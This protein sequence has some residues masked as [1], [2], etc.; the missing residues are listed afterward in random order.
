M[1]R[2]RFVPVIIAL[3][4]LLIVLPLL[5]FG[6]RTLWNVDQNIMVRR[7]TIYRP[8][9]IFNN[10]PEGTVYIDPLVKLD[11][12]DEH[13]GEFA[14]PPMK[15]VFVSTEEYD[16]PDWEWQECPNVNE[17]SGI[18][19]LREN[20]FVSLSL[21]YVPRGVVIFDGNERTYLEFYERSD[22][23][24]VDRIF[25]RYGGFRAAYVDENGNVLGI[26]EP[27][28]RVYDTI[29]PTALIADGN[30]LTFRVHGI[31]RQ[32]SAVLTAITV[33]EFVV[34]AALTITLLLAAMKKLYAD[35]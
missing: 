34:I 12:D 7:D 16:T 13:Y 2:I 22:D 24:N 1:K 17:S 28:V 4:A 9:L 26:T 32:Q 35:Q 14:A 23:E 29:L 3:A 21:H 30:T 25:D 10:A 20:G 19:R 6:L 5:L 8:E 18:A 31:P 27:A 11:A 33:T 15:L